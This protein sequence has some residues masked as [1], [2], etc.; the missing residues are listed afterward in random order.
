MSTMGII[1][2]TKVEI[3]QSSLE[4]IASTCGLWVTSPH[5]NR[6]KMVRIHVYF[7]N[8]N[9]CYT[10]KAV[11]GVNLARIRS[12][13]N[14]DISRSEYSDILDNFDPCDDL[15]TYTIPLLNICGCYIPS[16]DDCDN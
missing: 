14:K 15:V 4:F 7:D 8:K 16:D 6:N 3:M 12:I 13:P 5:L 9:D 2:A 1:S 10:L 11:S